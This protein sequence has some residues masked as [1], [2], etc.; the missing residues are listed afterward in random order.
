M[1]FQLGKEWFEKR[2]HLEEDFEVGA[3]V[4]PDRR[5][6][7][8]ET[9][10]IVQNQTSNEEFAKSLAFGT[11]IQFLRRDRRLSVEQLASDAKVDVAEVVKIEF[12]PKYV[13]HPRSVHQLASFFGMPQR[14]LL[15]LSDV[16]TVHNAQLR[17]AVYRFTAHSSEIAELSHE[18]R[19]AMTEFVQFLG[20]QDG[21]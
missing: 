7:G 19:V 21:D 11:L 8:H 16:S 4:P 6:C 13:P 14:A 10:A 1:K 2:I 12:D 17:A 20:T 5:E 15:K 18:E 3:G 9:T